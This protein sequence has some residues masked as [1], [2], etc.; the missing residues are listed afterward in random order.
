MGISRQSGGQGRPAS[1]GFVP[2]PQQGIAG[3]ALAADNQGEMIVGVVDILNLA[4]ATA[5]AAVVLVLVWVIGDRHAFRR[6]RARR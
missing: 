4:A 3:R 6:T 2:R 5:G 1:S